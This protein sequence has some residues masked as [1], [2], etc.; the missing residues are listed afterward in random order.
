MTADSEW[1]EDEERVLPVAIDPTITVKCEYVS[2]GTLY[3]TH[4]VQGDPA[5]AHNGTNVQY[6]G[7]YSAQT[8]SIGEAGTAY[9]GDYNGQ[10]VLV[11][12][13]A[14]NAST[15]LPFS[16]NLV[17]NSYYANTRFKEAR[18][19]S[20]QFG[21]GWKLDAVQTLTKCTGDLS[22]YMLYIDGDGTYHYFNICKG[23]NQRIDPERL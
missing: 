13:L 1:I 6:V 10:L 7:Y 18:N 3:T 21:N 12:N 9:V 15:V 17:Y 14:Y 8:Q 22:N 23:W 16:L 2:G 11:K 19:T 5:L 20:M 4:V